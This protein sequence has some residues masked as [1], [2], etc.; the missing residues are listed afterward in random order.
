MEK[1][2]NPP[3]PPE[4]WTVQGKR[5]FVSG[6]WWRRRIVFYSGSVLKAPMFDET[7]IHA[8]FTVEG[9]VTMYSLLRLWRSN[10]REQKAWEV[11]AQMEQSIESMRGKCFGSGRKNNTLTFAGRTVD[12]TDGYTED[13]GKTATRE[14][15]FGEDVRMLDNEELDR[16]VRELES[17][18]ASLV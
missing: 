12:V 15:I 9:L 11:Y 5:V 14:E 2:R 16:C 17:C 3:S 7:G 6:S 13:D 10:E 18:D 4:E 8:V 1:D